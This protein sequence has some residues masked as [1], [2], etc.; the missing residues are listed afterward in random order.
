MESKTKEMF[1]F[2]ANICFQPIKQPDDGEMI[3][4]AHTMG[5]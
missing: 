4:S 5:I 1:S 2:F 3:K